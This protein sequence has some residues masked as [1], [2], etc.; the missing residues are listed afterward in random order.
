MAPL[1]FSASTRCFTRAT[2]ALAFSPASIMTIPPT[3]SVTPFFTMAPKR[4][5]CQIRTSAT[6]RISTGV[7]ETSFS[8]I[9]P[10]SSTLLTRPSPRIRD[11]SAWCARTPPP[12]FVLLRRRAS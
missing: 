9:A 4:G 10:M 8:K 12:K 5:W 7:V 3:L 11:W 2:T 6:S 1:V